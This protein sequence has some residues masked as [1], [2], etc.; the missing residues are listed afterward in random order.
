MSPVCFP[1]GEPVVIGGTYRTEFHSK[2]YVVGPGICMAME[3]V[4]EAEAL[5]RTYRMRQRIVNDVPRD[6]LEPTE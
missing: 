4:E 6:E 2:W 3:S 5:A 1:D